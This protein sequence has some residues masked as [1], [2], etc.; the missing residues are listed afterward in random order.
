VVDHQ[1]GRPKRSGFGHR[2]TKPRSLERVY[3]SCNAKGRARVLL[4]E[5]I[6]PDT[7]F[8]MRHA[9]VRPAMQL[10]STAGAAAGLTV[11]KERLGKPIFAK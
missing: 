9:A 3:L 7:V 10:Q 1:A 6:K 5:P 4:A 11:A 8:V 2:R